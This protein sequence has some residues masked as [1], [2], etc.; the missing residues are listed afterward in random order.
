[1]AML[2]AILNFFTQGTAG[3][4]ETQSTDPLPKGR[5]DTIPNLALM[6]ERASSQT[7]CDEVAMLLLGIQQCC[8]S[9]QKRWP[10]AGLGMLCETFVTS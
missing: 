5:C 8:G 9:M 3:W 6:T 1:M 2:I 10:Y 4:R 7:T